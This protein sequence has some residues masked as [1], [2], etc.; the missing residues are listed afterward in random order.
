MRVLKKEYCEGEPVCP[1]LRYRKRD[2]EEGRA[3][4]LFRIHT[5][6]SVT[7]YAILKTRGYSDEWCLRF[8]ATRL[9][10]NGGN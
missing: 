7:E 10:G 1:R 8:L 6:L 5:L 9:Q 4:L 2:Q 3:D